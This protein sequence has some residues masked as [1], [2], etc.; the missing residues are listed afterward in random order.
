MNEEKITRGLGLYER[1]VG[2]EN[3]SAKR[4]Y[5]Q[6]YSTGNATNCKVGK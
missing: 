3:E 2:C 4:S 1:L 5:A 6:S